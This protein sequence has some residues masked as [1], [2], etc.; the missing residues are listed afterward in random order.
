MEKQI[1]F[2]V[3]LVNE[4]TNAH[5]TTIMYGID[6]YEVMYNLSDIIEGGYNILSIER[7]D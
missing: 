1:R 6:R 7:E 2:K 4:K 5:T 3:E